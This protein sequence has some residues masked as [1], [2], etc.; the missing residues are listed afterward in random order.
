MIGIAVCVFARP[1]V[2]IFI[3]PFD[4]A[5]IDAGTGYLRTV[6]S[7][8]L[9][10][11]FLFLFYGY[12]RA[13]Q[14]PGFSVVLTVISLG[15]RVI[16]AYTLSAIPVIGVNGIWLSIPIGW[17]LADIVGAVGLWSKADKCS[18]QKN[19]YGYNE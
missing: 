14:R 19:R 17:L 7:C 13:V 2:G 12:Y 18:N 16:L 4:A 5:M 10:I 6:A 15:S 11:G 1:L 3:E 8:Y 9:G